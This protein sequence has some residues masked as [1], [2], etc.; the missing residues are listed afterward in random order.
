MTPIDVRIKYRFDTG[1]APTYGHDRMGHNYQGG[2]TDDYAEWLENQ[3]TRKTF[4]RFMYRKDTG[5]QPTII[6]RDNELHFTKGYKESL[7]EDYCE[8]V[9]LIR[10]K[11]DES[12]K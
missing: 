4:K 8:G 2:L 1:L 9:K 12:Y 11:I 3:F 10:R 7:E 6:G 5:L